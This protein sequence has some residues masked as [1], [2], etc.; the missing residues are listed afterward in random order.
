MPKILFLSYRWNDQRLKTHSSDAMM[1]NGFA[2]DGWCCEYHDYREYTKNHGHRMNQSKIYRNI[3]NHNPDIVFITKGEKVDPATIRKCRQS[4]F[5]GK[6]IGW[7]NDVRKQPIKCVI[8]ISKVCDWF[9]HCIGGDDLK[10]YYNATKTPCSFLFSPFDP[11]FISPK[12]FDERTYNVTHYGQLYNPERGFDSMRRDIVPEVRDLICDY[13]ACFDKGFI[14]GIEYYRALGNS[15]MSISIPAID[16]PLYFS[17]R[18][19]HIMGSGSVVLSYDFKRCRDIFT[20]GVDIVTFKNHEEL[21]NKIKYYLNNT[22]E[23]EQIQKNSLNFAEKYLTSNR[24]Y[25]EIVYTLANG[26]SSYSFGETV[27]P[28][29]RKILDA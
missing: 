17:N 2:R 26:E 1:A 27:N 13:G 24:V 6:V 4:G 9:F 22:D 21:R 11:S 8:E 19:S 28:A 5:K 20:E 16:I 29:K 15:K 3:M 25:E 12:P 14:R 10:R 23:L 18:H 7:Y